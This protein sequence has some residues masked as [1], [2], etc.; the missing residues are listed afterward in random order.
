MWNFITVL[1]TLIGAGYG[2][3]KGDLTLAMTFL[4]TGLI[5]TAISAI[6]MGQSVIIAVD[7]DELDQIAEAAEKEAL[8]DVKEKE[9]E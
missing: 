9:N 1:C 5:I 3:Y 7:M 8:K 6:L 2:L 4:N